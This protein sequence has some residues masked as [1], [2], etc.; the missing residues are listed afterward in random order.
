M[1]N[2]T[3]EILKGIETP[4]AYKLLIAKDTTYIEKARG[5]VAI[6]NFIFKNG[7]KDSVLVFTK[8]SNDA[9]AFFKELKSPKDAKAEKYGSNQLLVGQCAVVKDAQGNRKLQIKVLDGSLSAEN[10][11]KEAKESFAKL[12]ITPVVGNFNITEEDEENTSETPQKSA[13]EQP[14]PVSADGSGEIKA[15]VGRGGVNNPQDVVIVQNLL[16][17]LGAKLTADG[18][19]GKLT[20]GAIDAFQKKLGMTVPDGLIEPGRKSW[21]ALVAG[22]GGKIETNP[23]PVTPV[24]PVT[25]VNPPA[26]ANSINASVGK[27]GNNALDDVKVVQSLLNKRGANLVVDGLCGKKTIA[28][29]ELLQNKL[30]IAV[31]G[32]VEPNSDTLKGLLSGTNIGGGGGNNNN[33][34]PPNNPAPATPLGNGTIEKGPVPSNFVRMKDKEVT[35]EMSKAAVHYLNV[36]TK[37]YPPGTRDPHY[38]EFIRFTTSDGKEILAH[39]EIHT[40]YGADLTKP[41]KPHP[42]IGLFKRKDQ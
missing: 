30:G 31:T 22:T 26:N 5:I 23:A 36:F 37:T 10:L 7:K 40:V 14:A 4:S 1:K 13:S 20:I 27:G 42:S 16:N 3:P 17:K 32:L 25:P 33:T 9:K 39:F 21:K 41:Q 15:S 28:V 11:E 19:C 29:I 6:K 35:K 2:V 34:T 8:K 18:S 12:A 38:G 24:T